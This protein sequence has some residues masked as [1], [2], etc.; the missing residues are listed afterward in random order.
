[1]GRRRPPPRAVD[2]ADLNPADLDPADLDLAARTQL[3]RNFGII[4][5]PGGTGLAGVSTA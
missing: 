1:M 2:P 5:A 3:S 4:F